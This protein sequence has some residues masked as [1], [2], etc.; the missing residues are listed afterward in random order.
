MAR[1]PYFEAKIKG[2]ERFIEGFYFAYPET[3]YCFTEDYER[4]PVE[5]I[6]CIVTHRMSD[7]SLPNHAECFRIEPDTLRQIGWFDSD[8]R[9]Y[10]TEAWYEMDGKYE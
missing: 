3:T 2:Q 6:H 9:S 5:I 4:H 7:W 1:I 8:R 10:G